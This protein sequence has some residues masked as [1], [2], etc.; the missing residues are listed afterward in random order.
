[1]GRASLCLAVLDDMVAYVQG[2]MGQRATP[3]R[4]AFDATPSNY[5][6]A[7]T[8]STTRPAGWPAPAG[9]SR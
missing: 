1:M 4:A 3:M 5:W 7:G 9:R 2:Q 6:M 8:C